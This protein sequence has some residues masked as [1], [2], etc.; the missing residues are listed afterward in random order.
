MEEVND[1]IGMYDS[2]FYIVA[3][4]PDSEW[5]MVEV[6]FYLVVIVVSYRLSRELERDIFNS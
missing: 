3:T 1:V 2:M 5:V 4:W 6:I